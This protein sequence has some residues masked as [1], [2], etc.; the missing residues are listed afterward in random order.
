MRICS[1]H[2]VLESYKRTLNGR[3][4]ILESALPTIFK[5]SEK[6][7]PRDVR[8][9]SAREKRRLNDDIKT[10]E[11]SLCADINKEIHP[12]K[13]AEL[14]FAWSGTNVQAIQRD[15]SNC[16]VA[17]NDETDRVSISD[18]KDT[19]AK[20]VNSVSCQIHVLY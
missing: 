20:K 6:S 14:V 7:S 17:E 5:P 19:K 16:F 13:G 15:H 3:R 1:A 4:K 10:T 18:L 12:V 8:Y 2:F 11:P 9:E